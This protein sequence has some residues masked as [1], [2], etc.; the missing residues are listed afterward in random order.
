MAQYSQTA[1]S[2]L[3]RWQEMLWATYVR[4]ETEAESDEFYGSAAGVLPGSQRLSVVSSTSQRTRR[5]GSN[6]RTDP[7]EF[8]LMAIQ[9]DG[10]GFVEQGDRQ[11]RTRPGDFV[12]YETTRPYTLCFEGPFKQL[13]LKLP[14]KILNHRLTNLSAVTARTFEGTQGASRVVREF[15]QLLA[16]SA[17]ELGDC[18][19]ECFEDAAADMIAT[20]CL[21]QSAGL[22]PDAALYSEIRSRLCKLVRDPCLDLE[23][24]A[25]S[26]NMSLRSLHR[27]FQRH[28]TTPGK[29]V[30]E[31]RLDGAMRDLQSSLCKH[32]MIGDIA[33]S[34]GFSDLSHFN[35][36][37]RIK[38]GVTPGHV[39]QQVSTG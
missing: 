20:A 3:S 10:V 21:V 13:V 36:M 39:R 11:A 2:N 25:I 22:R 26:L 34:W 27:L 12:L 28:G 8:T 30:L 7:S 32:R 14:R 5:T 1:L 37:F 24:L 17:G 38:Y 35:R 18:G 9:M 29:I 4:L 33:F 31:S 23:A 15:V 6:I 16:S 19:L